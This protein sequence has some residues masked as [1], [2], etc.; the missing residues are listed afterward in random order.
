MQRYKIGF[1]WAAAAIAA[2]IAM[3]TLADIYSFRD[4]KGV[5]HFTN[6]KGLDPRF[7]LVRKEGALNPVA[8]TPTA[9]YTPTADELQRYAAIVKTASQTYGVDASLVHAVISAE[10]NYNPNAVS[11]T[12]AQGIMQLMPDTAKRYGVQNSMD[13]SQNIHA[14]TKYLRDLLAMFKGK[15][16]LALAAYN[17]GENAVI[18][19]GGIPP[20]AET[21]SYVPRVLGFYR[22]FQK[23]G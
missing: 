17:A 12:G 18:R 14:G 13:P 23:R 11:R 3:P 21:R 10:S 8:Y 2:C 16:E 19:S 9:P 6:I 4:E 1:Q 22:D 20:Y 7:M 5:V 15:V